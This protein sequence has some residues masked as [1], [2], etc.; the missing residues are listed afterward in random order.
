MTRKNILIV[1]DRLKESGMEVLAVNLACSLS[2]KHNVIV[3][4][5]REGGNLEK[6]LQE[7]GVPYYILRRRGMRETYKIIKMFGYI[8]RHNIDIIY[9][10]N[11]GSSFW[12]GLF[13]FLTGKKAISH[14]HGLAYN[15]SLKEK[16]V[17]R[18]VSVF[19]KKIMFISKNEM[20]KF[21]LYVPV[22]RNKLT[23]VYNGIIFNETTK[24]KSEEKPNIPKR[25][26]I[27]AALRK[28]KKHELFLE[29][30]KKILERIPDIEFVVV[31]D[32]VR[33]KGLI[34][35]ADRLGITKNVIFTGF[36]EDVS[37]WMTTF[38]VGVLCSEREGVPLVLLEYLACRIPTVCTNVGGI[39]EVITHNENGLLI[40]SGNADDLATS[41]T[42]LLQNRKLAEKLSDNGYK[43]VLKKFSFEN[44]LRQTET[45]LLDC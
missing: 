44:M 26:G 21:N 3:V 1:I 43:T 22:K 38:D 39:P 31:G 23:I 12:G 16:F 33:K 42:M 36:Q 24:K 41:I 17:C 9:S 8:R 7:H 29:A 10:H 40:E 18:I 27:V 11:A 25:V 30:A 20:S 15:N 45:I 37:N 2:E 19:S 4:A 34:E 32:G 13:A 35:M 6:E 28:E 14:I 5:T